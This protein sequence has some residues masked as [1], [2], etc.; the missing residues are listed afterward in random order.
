MNQHIESCLGLYDLHQK[1]QY[2]DQQCHNPNI[3]EYFFEYKLKCG[4]N[5]KIRQDA[6]YIFDF[7]N[8]PLGTP[9]PYNQKEYH[10]NIRNER[11][12]IIHAFLACIRYPIM[13]KQ[14]QSSTFCMD[15]S[16]N[17]IVCSRD[18]FDLTQLLEDP[19]MF[20]SNTYM[21]QC[22]SKLEC[23]LNN[24]QEL[25]NIDNTN[26][27]ISSCNTLDIL[28][29]QL[30]GKPAYILGILYRAAVYH[31]QCLEMQAAIFLRSVFEW[32]AKKRDY[33]GSNPFSGL[34]KSHNISGNDEVLMNILADI[35]HSSTHSL[36]FPKFEAYKNPI[37]KCLKIVQKLFNTEFNVNI[38]IPI[39]QGHSN[40][41]ETY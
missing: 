30:E 1:W 36:E 26:I 9:V 25:N 23:L 39:G 38:N 18:F 37:G 27:L 5:I 22:Q 40:M 13:K 29:S 11:I 28:L 33:P 35:R 6:F 14:K 20:S 15:F 4:L 21:Q 41:I 3:L 16:D 7:M 2:Y 31:H 12:E 10:L 34:L 19:N 17:Y 24:K 32:L 8:A